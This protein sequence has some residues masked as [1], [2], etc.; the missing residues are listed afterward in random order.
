ML[1]M[2]LTAVLAAPLTLLPTG[3]SHIRPAGNPAVLLAAGDIATC[4]ALNDSK[5]ADIINAQAG[6]VGA[7]GDEVYAPDP[8]FADCYEPTWGQFKNRTRPALG[9]HEYVGT[10]NATYFQYF[11]AA[12][13]PAPGGYYSYD[14]GTW[15]IVVLNSICAKVPDGCGPGSAQESWLRDDL[16][17]NQSAC[18]LAY[19]HTPLF[20][21]GLVHAGEEDVRPLFQAL[22]D[23]GAEVVLN[24]ENRQ[25]ERFAPQTPAGLADPAGIREFVVGT[26]GH[27]LTSFG[28]IQPNSQVRNDATFG[29]LKLTL[30][31]GS[32]SW[33]FL[34]IAGKT[35]TDTGSGTCVDRRPPLTCLP[36]G[37][38][39]SIN[40]ALS[41]RG[42]EAKLC[43]GATFRLSA[44]IRYTAADQKIFTDGR[45][46]G[47]G[48]ATIRIVNP[49]MTTAIDGGQKSGISLESVQV[50][51][52]R[53]T[54]GYLGGG[55]LIEFGGSATD[56]AIV[57]IA[58]WGTRSW[59]TVHIAEGVV[60]NSVPACQ[61]ATIVDNVVGPAGTPADNE[62]ADG[63]SM[64]CGNSV[65]QRNT[66]RDATDA[67]IA[68]FGAPG[69]VISENT[70]IADTQV[71]LGGINM[72]DVDPVNGNFTRT[73]VTDNTIDARGAA[74]KVGLAMGPGVWHCK[75]GLVFGAT[76][77]NNVLRGNFMLYGLSA[78]GI[79][80]WTVSGNIDRSIHGP[81]K[82]GGCGGLPAT[83]L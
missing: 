14:L 13:G 11:G 18:T 53:D 78:N 31:V 38:E 24:G 8:E 67:A 82:A 80:N 37:T 48:R 35:F 79:T 75:P 33:Q 9:D 20:T 41:A 70:I 22:Y 57:R 74:I 15:H 5:T 19:W 68:I 63:F 47:G 25:Y 3:S 54:L 4:R 39:A 77:T 55:A 65:L 62:W 40:A 50:D 42:S 61:R 56:Q 66:I 49:T 43:P 2:V 69:S 72:V 44:P 60:T 16:A 28:T 21:S 30:D 6:T 58:A 73:L 81:F 17:T 76:V 1:G 34:P 10:S 26:G 12:A 71:L 7:I 23:Y 45:P 32:Y 46:I 64:A 51:G 27:A 52:G 83:P 29:V 59:S 36:S